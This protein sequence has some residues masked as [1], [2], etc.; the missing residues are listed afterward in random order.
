MIDQIS[1]DESKMYS[2]QKLP[3]RVSMLPNSSTAT[4]RWDYFRVALNLSGCILQI[5][6]GYLPQLGV[7]RRIGKT[8]YTVKA[9]PAGIAF[10]IWGI[11]FPLCVGYGIYQVLPGQHTNPLLRRIGMFSAV[12][13]YATI[14]WSLIAILA[15]PDDDDIQ[16]YV[17]YEWILSLTLFYGI[18]T[19]LNYILF[20][21]L[22]YHDN[23]NNNNSYNNNSNNNNNNNSSV[24]FGIVSPKEYFFVVLPLSIFAA[25]TTLASFVNI[26][27]ALLVSGV[28]N[29]NVT[30]GVQGGTIAYLFCVGL[31]I[32]LL[33]FVY[34]G[35]LPFAFVTIWAYAWIAEANFASEYDQVGVLAT[36]FTVLFSIVVLVSKLYWARKNALL[37]P[38]ST[39]TLPQFTELQ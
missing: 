23:S 3:E 21:L 15:A 39:A 36:V 7:G 1:S 4:N 28:E 11:I 24:G 38:A 35:L 5:A 10:S 9:Q 6:T 2:N 26:A 19:P 29:F 27:N 16:G 18:A 34:R 37:S 25:W 32:A 12:A 8:P 13:F 30:N 17:A 31:F 33:I 20:T 22:R 14:Q